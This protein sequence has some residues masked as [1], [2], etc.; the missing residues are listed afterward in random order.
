MLL[1]MVPY[2]LPGLAILLPG[3]IVADP[4]V[5]EDAEKTPPFLDLAEAD[6]P[7]TSIVR[8]PEGSRLPISVPV[9]SEDAGDPLVATLWVNFGSSTLEVQGPSTQLQAS[10]FEERR[11]IAINWVVQPRGDNLC[12]QLTLVVTHLP[13]LENHRPRDSSD[14]AFA[15]WWVLIEDADRAPPLLEECPVSGGAS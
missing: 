9:W 14:A 5:F 2:G 4:P 8:A 12:Q 6:P 3:C 7:I 11:N 1:A 10:T 13:N 15:T